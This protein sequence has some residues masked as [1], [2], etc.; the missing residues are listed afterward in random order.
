MHQDKVVLAKETFL[1]G[2]ELNDNYEKLYLNLGNMN[3][4]L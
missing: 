2:I 1:K 4:L 3:F